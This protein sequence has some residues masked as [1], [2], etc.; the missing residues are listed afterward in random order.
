MEEAGKDASAISMFTPIPPRGLLMPC[1]L[2][3]D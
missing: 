1:K 3:L 2:P